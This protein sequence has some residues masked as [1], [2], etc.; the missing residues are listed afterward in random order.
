MFDQSAF[1]RAEAFYRKADEDW[2][3]RRGPDSWRTR[4][5]YNDLGL[6]YRTLGKHDETET[7]RKRLLDDSIRTGGPS[8]IQ[9]SRRLLDNLGRLVQATKCHKEAEENYEKRWLGA[10]TMCKT[11]FALL[12]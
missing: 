9:G 6:A 4:R 8:F 3:R 10:R 11:G 5:A 2:N 7:L 12:Q 1:Q